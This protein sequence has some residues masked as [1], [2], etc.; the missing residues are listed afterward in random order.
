MRIIIELIVHLY[1]KY[2]GILKCDLSYLP[3]VFYA[4]YLLLL[5]QGLNYLYQINILQWKPSCSSLTNSILGIHHY[6]QKACYILGPT[7]GQDNITGQDDH[8]NVIGP[9]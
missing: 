6:Q 2:F 8:L 4:E 3:Y 9:G 5:L 1:D 7:L